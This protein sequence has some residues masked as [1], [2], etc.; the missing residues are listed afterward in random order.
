[1]EIQWYPGHMAK[2]KRMIQEMLPQVDAVCEIVDARIPYSSHNP[3]LEEILSRK[4]KIIVLN[5]D[6]LADPKQSSEWVNYYLSKGYY[7][8]RANALTGDGFP[9]F[10]KTVQKKSCLIK[11]RPIKVEVR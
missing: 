6:D 7:S 5:R 9:E 3:D 1:M 10:R 11:L 8:V 2:T 4:P